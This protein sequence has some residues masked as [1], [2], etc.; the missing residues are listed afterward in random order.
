MSPEKAVRIGLVLLVIGG[1]LIVFAATV[2]PEIGIGRFG[3]LLF[4]TSAA[5]ATVL[6]AGIVQGLRETY[7]NRRSADGGEGDDPGSEPSS[8][9][10]E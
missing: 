8:E 9:R 3:G 1:G 7:L 6:V 5:G 4:A 10:R 2:A